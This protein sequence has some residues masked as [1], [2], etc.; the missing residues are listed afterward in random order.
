MSIYLFLVM[1]LSLF[2]LVVNAWFKSMTVCLL[3]IMIAIFG[4]YWAEQ[5][6]VDFIEYIGMVIMAVLIAINVLYLVTRVENW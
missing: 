6:T 5:C 2:I 3:G 4:I 1:V